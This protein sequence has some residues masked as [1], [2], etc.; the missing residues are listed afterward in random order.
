MTNNEII[1]KAAE[2][3]AKNGVIKTKELHTRFEDGDQNLTSLIFEDGDTKVM[4]TGKY[5]ECSKDDENYFDN[6]ENIKAFLKTAEIEEVQHNDTKRIQSL[7]RKT[8]GKR[9]ALYLGKGRG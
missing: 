2:E 6:E 8:R 7:G 1:L 3:L 4:A 9:F 5:P